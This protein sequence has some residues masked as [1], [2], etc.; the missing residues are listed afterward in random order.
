[1]RATIARRATRVFATAFAAGGLAL[2]A[3]APAMAQQT[4]LQ[5][6][7][8]LARAGDCVSCHTAQGGAPY[9]GGLRLDTPF[10]YMLSPNITPDPVTGI[11]RWSGDDFYRAM[12][13]GVNKRGQDM[14]PVMPYDFYTKVTRADIDAIFAYLKTVTPVTNNVT[15]N[16]LYFP[17]NQRWSMGAWRELFFSEGTYKPDPAKSA[18][19]NRGAYLVE[20]LG[21]CSDC[22]SPRDI[23]GGI[24]KS[25]AFQ[26]AVID[27]WF[28]LNL[29]SN[30]HSGLGEWTAEE[31]AT[32]LKTGVFRGKTTALGPM[33]EV[34]K[35]STSYMTDDDLKAMGE[36]LKSIPASSPLRTARAMPSD[37]RIE[38]ASLYMD[39]CGG[40]HQA[41]GRGVPNVFP[42]LA[43]NGVVLSKSPADILKV[44]LNGIPARGKYVP[45]PSF[46]NQLT[47]KGIADLAN[48]VRSSW[49]NTAAS[50]ATPEE[51]ARLRRSM[52]K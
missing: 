30:L 29:S 2:A 1:M 46:A 52:K 9:A 37:V 12:H 14:Y 51:V 24:E 16:H 39:H 45:M 10:G 18:S 31:I 8:Y 35:N 15:T 33:A 3:L 17:F 41:G 32:Y 20:G 48:Y 38:A 47:D 13:H 26:G 34:V 44:V 19:W 11:G 27:G 40:C 28:A 50:D 23:M 49:G 4:Q 5:R 25:K 43:G 36:Y 7:E 42:P 6:G 21:H 22:H